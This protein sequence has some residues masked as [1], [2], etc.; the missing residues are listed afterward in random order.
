M[1]AMNELD[2]EIKEEVVERLQ[3]YIAYIEM[4]DVSDL[5]E[6]LDPLSQIYQD[7]RDSTPDERKEWFKNW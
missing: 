3:K 2:I 4:G 5:Q 7:V 1:G 6:G